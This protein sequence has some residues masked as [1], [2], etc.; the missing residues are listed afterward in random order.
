MP[1]A[2]AID[3]SEQVADL[4]NVLL[5]A[6]GGAILFVWQEPGIYEAR[7]GFIDGSDA[8]HVLSLAKACD[9]MF[10]QTDAMQLL[11]MV[12]NVNLAL[13]RL[14]SEVGATYEFFRNQLWPTKDGVYNI[15]FWAFR[16]D[17]WLRKSSRMLE[18][19]Y[20]FAVRLAQEKIRLG[21]DEEMPRLETCLYRA[22]GQLSAMIE[23]GQGEK[24]IILYN[25]FARFAG[26]PFVALV[27][28]NP[29]MIDFGDMLVQYKNGDFKGILVR[30]GLRA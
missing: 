4:N 18:R 15:N 27:A 22:L 2:A 9:Y 21:Q 14:C 1:D 28:R 24:G 29:L 7:V 26:F 5:I 11:F 30:Q 3:A 13:E 12:P 10:L 20:E 17:D 25:R 8:G 19:G 6:D 16:Y 23:G